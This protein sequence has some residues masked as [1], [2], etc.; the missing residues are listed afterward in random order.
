LPTRAGLPTSGRRRFPIIGIYGSDG[1]YS[2]AGIL[3]LVWYN[4]D[5]NV[6]RI[7]QQSTTKE[8]NACVSLETNT[9]FPCLALRTKDKNRN[10]GPKESKEGTSRPL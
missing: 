1:G 6:S 5:E 7:A 8:N 4:I 10:N 9:K 3:D 2:R